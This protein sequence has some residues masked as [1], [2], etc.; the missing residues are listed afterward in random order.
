MTLGKAILLKPVNWQHGV[1]TNSVPESHVPYHCLQTHKSKQ[2]G[3]E[4]GPTTVFPDRAP[5][6]KIRLIPGCPELQISL[7]C[8]FTRTLSMATQER[9]KLHDAPIGGGSTWQWHCRLLLEWLFRAQTPNINEKR[10]YIVPVGIQREE[11]AFETRGSMPVLSRLVTLGIP[12][13]HSTTLS[14]QPQSWVIP[15]FLRHAVVVS[16]LLLR[17]FPGLLN[18]STNFYG[19]HK[20][21]NWVNKHH[22]SQKMTQK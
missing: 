21:Q 1:A 15:G 13:G 18:I 20:A 17:R 9:S 19:K 7:C 22:S 16:L 4:L 3:Q 8:H 5:R 14:S 6:N 2:A 10:S 11:V 12:C